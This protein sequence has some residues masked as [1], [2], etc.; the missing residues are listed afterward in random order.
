[1]LEEATAANVIKG[2]KSVG[3]A[4]LISHLQFANDALI[5]S[6]TDKDQILNVKAIPLCF[7]A[8]SS[9]KV[10]FFKSELK[11]IQMDCEDLQKLAYLFRCNVGSLPA[12]YLGL[13]YLSKS[14]WN[15]VIERL[16]KQLALWKAKYLSF[17]GS[18]YFDQI[19]LFQPP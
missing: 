3:S 1:M 18:Y 8:V 12:S 9:L 6:D 4:P 13:P 16:E 11:G 14:L 10:N 7:E 15:P 17:G 5:F 19:S 2:F